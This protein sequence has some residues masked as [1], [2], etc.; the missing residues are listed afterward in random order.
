[1]ARAFLRSQA[2]FLLELFPPMRR[3]RAGANLNCQGGGAAMAGRKKSKNRMIWPGRAGRPPA[4]ETAVDLAKGVEKY[5]ASV[6]VTEDL[7][8]ILTGEPVMS[9]LGKPL[10][11]TRWLRPPSEGALARFLGISLRTWT[12]YRDNEQL[13]PVVEWA[14]DIIRDYLLEKLVTREK[15]NVNGLIFVLENNYGM[16]ER[17]EVELRNQTLEEFLTGAGEQEF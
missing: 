2:L 3:A 8:D 4:Y 6:S 11:V 7:I 14:K 15:G 1:M 16:K 12:N 13:G 10:Q 17:S 5:F 9:D